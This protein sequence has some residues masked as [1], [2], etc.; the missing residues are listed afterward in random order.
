MPGRIHQRPFMHIGAGLPKPHASKTALVNKFGTQIE[1]GFNIAG[2]LPIVGMFSG[3]IRA[4][5]GKIQAVVG[6]VL[7]GT[8]AIGAICARDATT[9]ARYL[10]L[11]KLG[12]EH[13]LHGVLNVIRGLGEAFTCS[14]FFGVGN[15]VFLIPNL[16]QDDK[17]SPIFKYGTLTR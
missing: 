2:C 17:F 15:L 10:K 9:H 16:S 7:M 3:A 8:G 11:Q 13:T 6:L 1:K 14:A 5:L 4:T 12:Q